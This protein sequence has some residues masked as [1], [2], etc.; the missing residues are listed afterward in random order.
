MLHFTYPFP[1]SAAHLTLTVFG[2][3]GLNLQCGVMLTG[4]G[5][6][7]GSTPGLLVGIGLGS[8]TILPLTCT[9]TLG[10][11]SSDISLFASNDSGQKR[12]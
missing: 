3:I 10:G 2:R 7:F 6:R 8:C 1:Y 4:F 9:L 12:S 11:N 5:G